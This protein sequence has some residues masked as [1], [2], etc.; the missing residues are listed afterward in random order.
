MNHRVAALI[1]AAGQGKR[2][3][4]PVS[5]QFLTFKEKPLLYY[6]LRVFEQCPDIDAI[7]V[8]LPQDLVEEY[9]NKIQSD[10][11]IFKFCG[12]VPGG[13]ERHDSVSAGLAAL[14]D[15]YALVAIHDGVRPLIT[16]EIISRSVAAARD[17][18][19]VIVGMPPKDTIKSVV[20]GWIKETLDR[21]RLVLVQ[22]PQVFRVDLIREAYR[23][24]YASH[25]FSTDDAALVEAMGWPVQV[26]MG[27]YRN[28]KVTSPEDMVF[29]QA[30][31][32]S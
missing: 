20:D 29:V 30:F 21:S 24:A 22:T 26:V 13:M 28:I 18:G 19:A 5:K 12:A 6:T 15:E 4:G 2:F 14:P 11:G 7:W 32:E 17:S 16:S 10:W 31:L 1:V 27:D 25:A 9:S 23:Q 8:I 3:G